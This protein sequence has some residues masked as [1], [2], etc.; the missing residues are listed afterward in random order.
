MSRPISLAPDQRTLPSPPW[1]QRLPFSPSDKL[2]SLWS[3]SRYT[4]R[5]RQPQVPVRS[6]PS[7]QHVRHFC[8]SFQNIRC[9]PL[10][11]NYE[12]R[13]CL[14]PQVLSFFLWHRKKIPDQVYCRL[15]PLRTS[16][17]A[18]VA[19]W[20]SVVEDSRHRKV[21][22]PRS[23]LPEPSGEMCNHLYLSHR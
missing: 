9:G 11:L 19:L 14:L 4:C 17:L 15:E 6:A 12:S 22:E 16:L 10:L 13:Q 3:R 23:C 1:P 18:T 8:Y 20:V 21:A 2:G 5:Q 7:S